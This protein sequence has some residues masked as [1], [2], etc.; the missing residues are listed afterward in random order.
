[1]QQK[2]LF[3]IIIV[4][5]GP[6]GLACG[7]AAQKQGLSYLIVE[8]GCL[9]N[10]LYC[11]PSNMTFFSTPEKIEIGNIPFISHSERPSRQE[12]LEYYRRVS[13]HYQLN[14]KLYEPVVSISRPESTS[15]F[16]IITNR[17]TYKSKYVIVA[18]GFYDTPNYLED[19]EGSQLPKMKHYF[20]DP[21]LYAQQSVV[22]VGGGNSAV[23]AALSCWRKGA[24]VS[25]VVRAANL[26]KSIKY[27]VK[28]D[29]ENRIKEGSIKA[30]FNSELQRITPEQVYINTPQGTL[31]IPNQFVLAMTGYRPNFDFLQSIGIH[32]YPN[33]NGFLVPEYHPSTYQTN[34]PNVYLAGTVCGGTNTSRWYIENARI[35]ASKIVQHIVDSSCLH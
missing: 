27:W 8:K 24:E 7:I 3:D 13:A 9:V 19:I 6:I 23:D 11:Y 26:K 25:M 20:T 33:D 21:H 18:T 28:P 35:H 17:Q 1:M 10:S 30:Y 31:N 2:Q 34:V 32:C 29:I 12:G 16:N 15:V 5:A 4:G 14:V 22:V